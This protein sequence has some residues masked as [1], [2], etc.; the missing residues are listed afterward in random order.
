MAEVVIKTLID[1]NGVPYRPPNF[2]VPMEYFWEGL[3]LSRVIAA[4]TILN[5]HDPD[6]KAD[7]IRAKMAQNTTCLFEFPDPSRTEEGARIT[8]KIEKAESIM[9]SDEHG[10]PLPAIFLA[11]ELDGPTFDILLAY[12]FITSQKF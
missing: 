3:E 12:G 4:G 6:K 2:S 1:S 11:C 9:I 5:C 10:N 8:A 7:E